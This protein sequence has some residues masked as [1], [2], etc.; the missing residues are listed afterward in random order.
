MS[1]STGYEPTTNKTLLAAVTEVGDMD[2]DIPYGGGT[3]SSG[4]LAIMAP[5]TP[6]HP[7]PSQS[8]T[9]LAAVVHHGAP[10]SAAPFFGG[11]G[12]AAAIALPTR[13]SFTQSNISNQVIPFQVNVNVPPQEGSPG[14][15]ELKNEILLLKQQMNYMNLE[16]Y[17]AQMHAAKACEHESQFQGR[18]AE[19]MA[20]FE[21]S[22]EEAKQIWSDAHEVSMGLQKAE[23]T[24]EYIQLRNDATQHI[25]KLTEKLDETQRKNREFQANK[26][27]E[28]QARSLRLAAEIQEREVA[29]KN[30]AQAQ[31]DQQKGSHNQEVQ[32]KNLVI[33]Q[34]IHRISEMQDQMSAREQQVQQQLHEASQQTEIQKQVLQD[35]RAAQQATEINAH[36]LSI[37]CET[38]RGHL[39]N[40]ASELQSIIDRQA[41]TVQQF[42]QRDQEQHAILNDLRNQ[43][44]QR[45]AQFAKDKEQL[46]L[47]FQ[48]QL[49]K[50]QNQKAQQDRPLHQQIFHQ[51]EE[52]TTKWSQGNEGRKAECCKEEEIMQEAT[53]AKQDAIGIT[54]A[55]AGIVESDME[56]KA[57]ENVKLKAQLDQLLQEKSQMQ[58]QMNGL[59]STRSN[60]LP[61]QVTLIEVP[62]YIMHTPP[63]EQE[64]NA[65]AEEE[66]SSEAESSSEDSDD[67]PYTKRQWRAWYAANPQEIPHPESQEDHAKKK[68]AFREIFPLGGDIKH[69]NIPKP[70]EAESLTFDHWPSH[71]KEKTWRVET[72]RLIATSSIDPDACLKWLKAIRTAPTVKNLP[73]TPEIFKQLETKMLT[74]G[75]KCCKEPFKSEIKT[76]VRKLEHDEDDPRMFPGSEVFWRMLEEMK[77]TMPERIATSYRD[78]LHV[79]MIHNDMRKFLEQWTRVLEDAVEEPPESLLATLFIEQIEQCEP[80]QEHWTHVTTP[81]IVKNLEQTYKFA[82]DEVTIWQAQEKAKAR[83]NSIKQ[84][85]E[86][87]WNQ[88]APSPKWAAPAVSTAQVCQR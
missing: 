37:T 45:E 86:S 76:L 46:E 6:P 66:S 35:M 63:N 17:T 67:T 81:L 8:I 73:I 52:L 36:Q 47:E 83:A 30:A 58:N 34:G 22:A 87:A 88:G 12:S 75:I 9:P 40:E 70:H 11:G 1:I 56:E 3:G 16:L 50:I 65:Q 28:F 59:S 55:S 39:T 5:T 43:N 23:S 2:V 25:A 38:E 68:K 60:S 71:R 31:F 85:N 10:L 64:D 41:D 32:A 26:E 29:I 44:A 69:R 79:K 49:T 42:Q 57:R 19:I 20:R 7:S 48:K 51:D 18:A 21:A 24:K 15:L 74:A 77:R 80:F 82:M 62:E 78:I 54:P 72:V 14:K 53:Q 27:Q 13:G 61:K 33:Q 84:S 4:G